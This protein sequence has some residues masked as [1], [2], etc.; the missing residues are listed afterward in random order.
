MVVLSVSTSGHRTRVCNARCY[1]GKP[2]T[3]CRCV[4]GGKN[5]AVGL[6]KAIENARKIVGMPNGEEDGGAENRG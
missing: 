6:E 2:E 3:K 4:C 5:H 1:D